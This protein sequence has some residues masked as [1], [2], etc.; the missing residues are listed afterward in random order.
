MSDADRIAIFPLSS[1]AM[2]PGIQCPL[3]IFEPRYRQMVEHVLAGDGR[4]GMATIRPECLDEIEGDPELFETGCAGVITEHQELPDGRFNLVLLGT[5]R[6]RIITEEPRT[7]DRQFRTAR[8]KFLEDPV[9]EERAGRIAQ[10]RPALLEL[11]N[12]FLEQSDP[13]HAARFAQRDLSAVDDTTLVNALSNSFPLSTSDKQQLLSA[14]SISER[15]D[16]LMG[17]LEVRVAESDAQGAVS[18]RILH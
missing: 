12:T 3:H 18:T 2:F 7:G 4:I 9:P 6:F 10:L 5:R 15:L 16:R 1:V 17:V 14:D 11:V 8:V 13:D